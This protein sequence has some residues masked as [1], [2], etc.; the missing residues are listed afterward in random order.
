M[1]LDFVIQNADSLGMPDRD[2]FV[3]ATKAGKAAVHALGSWLN[4]GAP[5]APHDVAAYLRHLVREADGVPYASELGALLDSFASSPL[6]ARSSALDQIEDFFRAHRRNGLDM[7]IERAVQSEA[8][9]QNYDAAD[10]MTT[11]LTAVAERHLVDARGG[12][13]H[14]VG[15]DRIVQAREQIRACIEPA[16]QYRACK[17][18]GKKP[19]PGT[20]S[21][22]RAKKPDVVGTNLLGAW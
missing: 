2:Q 19:R 3:S 11:A 5:D 18:L 9:R 20:P 1:V 12:L 8:A 10:V 13:V 15:V 21:G 6:E 14:E 4:G 7:A 16:A 22:V 17:L